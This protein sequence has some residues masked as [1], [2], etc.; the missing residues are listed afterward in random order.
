MGQ[1]P[2]KLDWLQ[3]V[4]QP[5][6]GLFAALGWQ[7]LSALEKA[8]NAGNALGHEIH[9][10]RRSRDLLLSR[11]LTGQMAA[12]ALSFAKEEVP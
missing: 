4:E 7:A 12:V 2:L 8:F 3:L 1:H 5:V 10:F 11:L 6:I 9:N